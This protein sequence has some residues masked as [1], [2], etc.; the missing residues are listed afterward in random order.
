MQGN[1]NDP[2]S[3]NGQKTSRVFWPATFKMMNIS[4]NRVAITSTVTLV[5]IVSSLFLTCLIMEILGGSLDAVIIATAMAVPALIAPVISW[6]FIILLTRIY[7]LEEEQ[8]A[9]ATFDSLTGVMSRRPFLEKVESLVDRAIK[10]SRTLS[11]AYLDVDN[12]KTI[13]E[14][15]GHDGGDAV[16]STFGELLVKTLRTTDLVGRLGGEEFVIALPDTREKDAQTILKRIRET[17]ES[18]GIVYGNQIIR[19]TVSIGLTILDDNNRT[20]FKE[21][22][23]QAD[24]AL[25]QAKHTGK[26]RIISFQPVQK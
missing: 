11:I 12:F 8:R 4:I 20:S 17:V 6:Y 5:S 7:Q 15:Y 26:N 1:S 10:Q 25:F 22:I 2:K 21:L 23:T 19:Y 18:Q 3:R 16:L 14:K 24:K 13:N 9:L